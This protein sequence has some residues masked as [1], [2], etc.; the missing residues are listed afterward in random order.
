MRY[1]YTAWFRNTLARPEDQD[2]EWP[3]CFLVL[4]K[5]QADAKAWGDHLSRS[6]SQRRGSEEFFASKIEPA[7]A[8][9]AGLPAV[10]A[11]HEA[12][13]AEIGW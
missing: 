5:T 3:A 4:A 7:S 12:S 6:F 10:L 11:G 13:D 8:D 2:F 1:T 9:C